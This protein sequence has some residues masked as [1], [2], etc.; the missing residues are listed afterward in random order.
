MK[1][2][3]HRKSTIEYLKETFTVLQRY[4]DFPKEAIEEFNKQIKEYEDFCDWKVGK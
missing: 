2:I 1:T 4:I 3:I